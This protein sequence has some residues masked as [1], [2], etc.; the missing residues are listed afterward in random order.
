MRA[1]V[2]PLVRGREAAGA[3]FRFGAEVAAIRKAADGWR[4]D[5]ASAPAD[6][7][8]Y[9]AVVLSA[10]APQAARLAAAFPDVV[11]ALGKVEIAPCWALM[12]AL[13]GPWRRQADVFVDA[14]PEIAWLARDG[15]K[16]GRAE[17]GVERWV[18]HASADWSCAHLELSKEAAAE[19]ML[20]LL[21]ARFGAPACVVHAVAH[22]WRYA[23]VETP[24]GRPCL[25][26][27]E[28]GLVLCGDW[29]L[30]ARVEAA[31]DSGDAAA[32]A[33]IDRFSPEA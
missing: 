33:I 31:F 8:R 11:E 10:P 4:L 2:A 21:S 6:E 22:R 27:A 30:G 29:L 15:S 24:L 20:A 25:E 5:L 32:A 18:A 1:L 9:D 7:E 16:P 3:R 23:R 14:A 13:D 17:D 26:A 28:P 19:A 12:L